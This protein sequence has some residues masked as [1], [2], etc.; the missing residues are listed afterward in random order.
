VFDAFQLRAMWAS[1]TRSL[2]ML[3]SGRP[4]SVM[5]ELRRSVLAAARER[6][7][8]CAEA[9]VTWLATEL[10]SERGR[11][12]YELLQP[13]DIAWIGRS[14]TLRDC[15]LCGGVELGERGAVLACIGQLAGC[16]GH[17]QDAIAL[18]AI[19]HECLCVF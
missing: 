12:R 7:A 18:T 6:G 5:P 19:F 8:E 15:E 13:L 3:A 17:A 14:G 1:A 16:V 4:Q 11:E 2:S 9:N 10:G